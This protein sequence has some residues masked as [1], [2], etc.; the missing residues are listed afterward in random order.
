MRRASNWLMVVTLLLTG[1]AFATCKFG[2]QHAINQI[3]PETRRHMSDTDWVGTEWI[4]R[5]MAL[6]AL[7]VTTGIIWVVLRVRASFLKWRLENSQL[8]VRSGGPT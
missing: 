6:Q 5:G 4:F 2:V 7:A 3:P 1:A 8:G